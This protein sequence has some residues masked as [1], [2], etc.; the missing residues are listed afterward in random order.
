MKIQWRSCPDK[1]KLLSARECG[2]VCSLRA[3]CALHNLK[4]DRITFIQGSISFS[5]NR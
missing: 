4:F 1:A 2:H 3:F 5:L